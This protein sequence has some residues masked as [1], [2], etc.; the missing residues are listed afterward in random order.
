MNETEFH[1]VDKSAAKL[2]E[3]DSPTRTTAPPKR[4]SSARSVATRITPTT[5]PR[6]TWRYGVV[7]GY[8]V[9][10]RL[11]ATEVHP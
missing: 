3:T 4:T 1:A 11:V 5:T 6:R 7:G 8:S 10:P 9:A 2:T